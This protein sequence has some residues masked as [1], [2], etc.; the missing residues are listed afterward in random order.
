MVGISSRYVASER[1]EQRRRKSG[2][3]TFE[4]IVKGVTHERLLPVVKPCIHGRLPN[5]GASS[6]DNHQEVYSHCCNF[7]E[8]ILGSKARATLSWN[9]SNN[10]PFCIE[11]DFLHPL[12]ELS[13]HESI[14]VIIK[15]TRVLQDK[16]DVIKKTEYSRQEGKLITLI[17]HWN[18]FSLA[19]K[20][21]IMTNKKQ[22][23]N[24]R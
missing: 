15:E 1:N 23:M 20:K 12:L 6:L 21:S 3:T 4:G 10:V 14:D 11:E 22:V 9:A 24:Y 2:A 5:I 7:H 17:K 18:D 16:V 13:I 19:V 8:N